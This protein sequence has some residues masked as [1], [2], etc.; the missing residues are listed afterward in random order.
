MLQKQNIMKKKKREKKEEG[1]R[2][3]EV[4]RGRQESEQRIGKSCTNL[5]FQK[6]N[7]SPPTQTKLLFISNKSYA[8][9]LTF[10]IINSSLYLY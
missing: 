2:L 9:V 6:L 10:I 5:T 3:A 1:I 8:N 4:V 7:N